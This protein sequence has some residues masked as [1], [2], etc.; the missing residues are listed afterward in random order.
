MSQE[1]SVQSFCSHC[2]RSFAQSDL[3]QIAGSSVCADCK[4]AFLSR[5]MAS[6]A[7]GVFGRRYAGFW[8]RLGARFVDGIV[9]AVPYFVLAA[10]LIPSFYKS[11]VQG[12]PDPLT[13]F[14]FL[15]LLLIGFVIGAVYEVLMLKNKGATLGKMACGL[16]VIR[17][18]GQE[19]GWGTCFGRFFMWNIVT[20]GVPYLNFF[21]M[22]ITSIMIG[23][24]AE[25]RA[26]HDRVCDTRVVYK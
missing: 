5:V 22:T 13:G 26:I 16:K 23:V 17:S 2:G 6:G 9:F 14:Y 8:I 11:T 12:K 7:A 25:K 4:P 18:D 10:L 21:L 24:D 3:V 20:S 1:V 19:L 15:S